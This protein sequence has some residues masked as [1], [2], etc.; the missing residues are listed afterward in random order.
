MKPAWDA[1]GV[2]Y[3]DSPSVLI[4][5]VDCT[6]SGKELCEQ[7][8]V[9]GYPTIK[10]FTSEHPEG[11][12]YEGGRDVESLRSF[13]KDNLEKYCQIDDS[14]TC[15]DREWKY[16]LKMQKASVVEQK[17][18]FKRLEG[19]MDNPMKPALKAWISKRVHLLRQLTS[20]VKE[21]L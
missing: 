2:N 1:L 14:E 6:A 21:E 3:K 20:R 8:S 7:H 16:V 17:K 15:D 12:A 10:Y 13:V 18:Q 4:G 11:K 5:D 9:R 19:M